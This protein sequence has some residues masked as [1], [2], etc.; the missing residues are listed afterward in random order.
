MPH[1]RLFIRG[2][3]ARDLVAFLEYRLPF[4][5]LRTF[6]HADFRDMHARLVPRDLIL[7]VVEMILHHGHREQQPEQGEKFSHRA[8]IAPSFVRA[9][10]MCSRPAIF[11]SLPK[12]SSAAGPAASV[13]RP[14][15]R[16]RDACSAKAPRRT[17][18]A[19]HSCSPSPC[20][21]P[22]RK[23]SAS[24]K[25]PAPTQIPRAKARART[26]PHA[27]TDASPPQARTPDARPH[28]CAAHAAI[29]RATRR[30]GR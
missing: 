2:Q 3:F 27:S 30:A 23:V 29:R 5:L 12:Y 1:E 13:S 9:P 19:S 15:P 18:P 7:P 17:R 22:P 28:G 26:A 16:P 14:A 20:R 24:A 25:S 4:R 6:E 10:F 8:D 11:Q 21:L